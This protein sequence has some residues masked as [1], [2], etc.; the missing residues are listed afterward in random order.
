MVSDLVMQ[1][2]ASLLPKANYSLDSDNIYSNVLSPGAV[3]SLLH[4]YGATSRYA[5]VGHRPASRVDLADKMA[6][7]MFGGSEG[8]L[9]QD[10]GSFY[11]DA[12]IIKPQPTMTAAN[13]M[14]LMR[15]VDNTRHGYSSWRDAG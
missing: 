9:R 14:S 11:S 5:H 4:D 15:P 10:S 13:C 1:H 2:D 12:Y 3:D 7:Q 8:G 6:F